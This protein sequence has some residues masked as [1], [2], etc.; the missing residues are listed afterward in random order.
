MRTVFE[1]LGHHFE[2]NTIIHDD[3][4]TT[5]EAAEKIAKRRLDRRKNYAIINGEV[6][7]YG[8]W[9][10]ACSGCSPDDPYQRVDA[11][12]GCHECGYTGKRRVGFW[13]PILSEE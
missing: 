5:Y 2:G 3:R 7:E 8:E 13:G 9:T 11:G 12:A 10:Q 6:C 4:E 1:R